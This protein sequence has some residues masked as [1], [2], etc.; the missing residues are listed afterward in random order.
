MK[1]I[2]LI[3]T[4]VFFVASPLLSQTLSRNKYITEITSPNEYTGVVNGTKINV[5]VSSPGLGDNLLG[6]SPEKVVSIYLPP[7]YDN[8]P[9]NH[10]PVIYFLHGIF[11][12]HRSFFGGTNLPGLNFK[13]ILDKLINSEAV[14]PFIL[15]APNSNNKYGG[16]FYTN[17]YTTGQWEDFIVRDVVQYIDE[18]FR[19]LANR[20]SRGIAGHSMGGYGAIKLAMKYP[21]LFS[22]VYMFSPYLVLEDFVLGAQ[23]P[24]IIEAAEAASLSGLSLWAQSFVM[25]AA[26]F[27]PDSTYLPFFGQFPVSS[28]GELIDSIWQKWLSH[29]PYT[30][31]PAYKDSLLQ[32]KAIQFDCGKS[33]EYFFFPRCVK[34]SDALDQNGIDHIFEEY[35]GNHQ[36]RLAER[37]ETKLLPF[38]WDK[39]DYKIPGLSRK[40]S[41]Y[42]DSSDTLVLKIN[43]NGN[44]Y[45]VPGDTQALLDSIIERQIHTSIASE[46]ADVE[47][48]L[49]DI[50][51]G[52]YFAYGV[53]ES[54]TGIS[55]P[56]PFSVVANK[57]PPTITLSSDTIVRGDS[58]YA[59]SDKDG[60]IY[61][62]AWSTSPD[63]IGQNPM[64]S[65]VVKEGQWIGFSTI[66]LSAGNYRFYAMDSHGF[67]SEAHAL[68]VMA[69]TGTIKY[70]SANIAIYPNPVSD[71]FSIKANR[72][73]HY[74]IEIASINGLLI[75][76]G[77]N[78]G[79]DVQIDLSSFQ[80]GVYIITIRSKDFVTT[81]K[82]V[83]L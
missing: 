27:A 29:D 34:F 12:N 75:Y 3:L 71:V 9:N 1:R 19:T 64:A 30:M 48:P 59:A 54:K 11:G 60:M 35:E 61:L 58:V 36:S 74:T 69:A 41:W 79:T 15:V 78:A 39:L 76:E 53:N 28:S 25:Q 17:S 66:D 51:Y 50:A 56:I 42:L 23:K 32:L 80:K 38:F 5:M 67:I 57:Q 13:T 10:Y 72:L 45:V 37:I 73:S 20:D 81:R 46:G 22:A 33:D 2:G 24:Y 52:D 4:A 65:A 8:A 70:S 82:I 83:K 55:I 47:I 44:V 77:R 26:A 68:N 49:S 18:N 62:E 43:Q 14:S 21:A 31:I 6:E 40:S 7:G 16:S 63:K